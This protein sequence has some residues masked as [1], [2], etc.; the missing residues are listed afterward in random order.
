MAAAAEFSCLS[1]LPAGFVFRPT[2]EQLITHYL[3]NKNVGNECVVGFIKE[4][5]LYKLEPEQLPDKS[6]IPSDNFEWFFFRANTF[7]IERTTGTGS[8]NF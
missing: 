3:K 6:F 8:W 4:I 1:S 2:E 5:D 7:D